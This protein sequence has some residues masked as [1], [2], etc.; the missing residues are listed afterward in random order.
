VSR[1]AKV[2]GYEVGASDWEFYSWIVNLCHVECDRS[3]LANLFGRTGGIER[4]IDSLNRE[5]DV[6]PAYVS[7]H[8]AP[9]STESADY[10]V[11]RLFYTR[12]NALFIDRVR[13]RIEEIYPGWEL[14]PVRRLEKAILV[15]LLIYQAA[16]HANTSG[17]FKAYHKGFGGHG[18]DA[19]SRIL[20][21]MRLCIPVLVDGKFGC[22]S[23]RRNALSFVSGRPAD[24]AYLDPP[25]NV[26]QYGSNYFM[27]NTI[28][29]WD[30]PEVPGD[31]DEK[32]RLRE[33]AG[34]RR[35]WTETRSAYCSRKTASVELKS[36][37]DTIDARYIVMSYSS[38]GIIPFEELL[39][40]LSYH[41]RVELYGR[42]Y[43]VYRGGRQSMSRQTG[44]VEFV[45]VVERG[46][47][48]T[49]AVDRRFQR[50]KLERDIGML[51]RRS[52]VPARLANAFVKKGMT[53]YLDQT[54]GGDGFETELLYRFRPM[55]AET[56]AR[57]K[58]LLAGKSIEQLTD[59]R[60]R[61]LA[62]AASTTGEEAGVLL[63]LL[64]DTP[65]LSRRAF[66]V[67]RLLVVMRKFANRK[68]RDQFVDFSRRLRD[69]IARQPD[70]FP[71]IAG[72]L[73]ELEALFSRRLAG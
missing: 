9:S 37:M 32:G 12:E 4:T 17:V 42:D 71:G 27:L 3:Q 50:F 53:V 24:I 45:L 40:L 62:A 70:R 67:R 23:S 61:L 35:D 14:D 49:G 57:L 31:R 30:R 6:G 16:K 56:A 55:S 46:P 48:S 29:M 60:Q 19:L 10:R 11:E 43:T 41:G 73:D 64:C 52:F 22:T 25:Y 63:S 58:T 51:L 38:E 47:A 21:P 7:R 20:A 5:G 59:I 66:Y 69:A 33:K 54:L 8:Y 65:E 26:H 18:G 2:L 36:L 28:A 34:I 13:N 1:L 72:P 39:D 44:N 68:Y 15:S